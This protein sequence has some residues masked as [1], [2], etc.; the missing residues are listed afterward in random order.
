[1]WQTRR[2]TA[3]VV[4]PTFASNI[5][6]TS[7]VIIEAERPMDVYISGTFAGL[8]NTAERNGWKVYLT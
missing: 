8:R 3:K 6:V 1:M 7:G 4:G 2:Y 5:V